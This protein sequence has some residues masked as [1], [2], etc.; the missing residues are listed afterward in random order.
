M[1]WFYANYLNW[2]LGFGS[3]EKRV[4]CWAHCSRLFDARL[5]HITDKVVR[6]IKGKGKNMIEEQSKQRS[7]SF[8]RS[9]GNP[10]DN[11]NQKIYKEKPDI[12][13]HDWTR[14]LKWDDKQFKFIKFSKSSSIYCTSDS[15]K[16]LDRQKCKN[17]FLYI[18]NINIET[19]FDTL[20]TKTDEIIVLDY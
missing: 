6:F 8:M 4:N 2:Q 7:S 5:T 9:D 20:I 11:P 19:D 18:E 13:T 16:Q 14:A 10:L 17:F 3:I 15:D 12:E 1:L